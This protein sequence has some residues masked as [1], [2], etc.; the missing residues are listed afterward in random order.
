[1]HLEHQRSRAGV[2]SQRS[3]L[4]MAVNN[5]GPSQESPGT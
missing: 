3:N 1:M 4:G 5:A 2:L